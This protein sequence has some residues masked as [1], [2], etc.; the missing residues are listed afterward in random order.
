MDILEERRTW[1]AAKL[2]HGLSAMPIPEV[3]THLARDYRRLEQEDMTLDVERKLLHLKDHLEK[4]AQQ[5]AAAAKQK[6]PNHSISL[7]ETNTILELSHIKVNSIFPIKSRTATLDVE[8]ASITSSSVATPTGVEGTGCDRLDAN[9]TQPRHH[10][11]QRYP[12]PMAVADST[13]SLT[14]G[15]AITPRANKNEMALALS[16]K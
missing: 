6:D 13:Q 7:N 1:Y 14:K 9:M 5:R 8:I 16:G 11:Q 4:T 10:Q 15:H 2:K 12:S 3:P